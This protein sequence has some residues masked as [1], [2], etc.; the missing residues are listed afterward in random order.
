MLKELG[1]DG[2]VS[3]ASLDAAG[4]V[5]E[6]KGCTMDGVKAD[7][8]NAGLRPA[9]RA[10]A[11]ADSRRRPGRRCRCIRTILDLSQYTLKVTGLKE[12]NYT[13]KI[14][15][16]PTATLTAKELEAGVNLTAFGPG[17]QA[18]DASTPSWPRAR[19][20]LGAVAGKENVVGQWRDTSQKAHAADAAPELKDQLAALGKKVEEAD[21]KI[22]EAARPQKLHFELSPA[23]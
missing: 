17:P 13:L 1:A 3:S 7:G 14:N 4:K 9:R 12:G 16:I 19:A 2:F 21:E 22:R 8:R 23:Q 5:A 10:A 20:I 18:E 15:G 6:A 11:V